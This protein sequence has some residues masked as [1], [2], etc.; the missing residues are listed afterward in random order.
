MVAEETL[1]V[2]NLEKFFPQALAGWRA[3]VQPM[4]RLTVPALRGVSFGISRGEAVA[5]VGANGA[6]KSTLL[7]I[8]T[9]LL[10][11]TRGQAWGGGAS[12]VREPAAVRRQIGFHS[13]SDASFYARLSGRENLRLFAALNNISREEAD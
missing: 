5:L 7:R 4:S 11:P 13:G 10:V 6:G 1:R 2:E 12:V 8:L 3:F 9:T